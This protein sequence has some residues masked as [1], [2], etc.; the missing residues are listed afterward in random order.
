MP[1]ENVA[2]HLCE[3]F[4]TTTPA[5]TAS[6]NDSSILVPPTVTGPLAT[7]SALKVIVPFP[8][9]DGLF[10]YLAAVTGLSVESG[11]LDWNRN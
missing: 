9:V 1:F 8:L 3:P 11:S 4:C 5:S 2:I 6:A 10:A 7:R